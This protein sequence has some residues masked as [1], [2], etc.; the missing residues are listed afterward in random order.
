MVV[1]GFNIVWFAVA[2]DYFTK[3]GERAA[4]HAGCVGVGGWTDDY[5]TTVGRT[6]GCDGVGCGEGA[7]HTGRVGNGVRGATAPRWSSRTG[8]TGRWVATPSG[9]KPVALY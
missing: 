5:F 4:G 7:G 8:H 3:V 6:V 9:C 1:S 2:G